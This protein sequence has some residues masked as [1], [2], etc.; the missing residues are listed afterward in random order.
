[1]LFCGMTREKGAETMRRWPFDRFV[2]MGLILVG[3]FCLLQAGSKALLWFAGSRAPGHIVSVDR[4]VSKTGAFW[5]SYTF[6]TA[7]KETQSGSAMSAGTA[8]GALHRRIDVAYLPLLPDINMPAYGGYAAVIG[9]GWTL[10]GLACLGAGAV[11]GKT[12]R[13]RL[14]P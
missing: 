5:T 12:G 8:A 14:R 10:A 9:A 6:Q 7:G 1:M 2:A 3:T 4:G 13:G 11:L